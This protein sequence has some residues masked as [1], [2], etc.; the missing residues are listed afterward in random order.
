[1]FSF[2]G[3]SN[4]GGGN[5]SLLHAPSLTGADEIEYL[6]PLDEATFGKVHDVKVSLYSQSIPPFY[7]QDRFG[8]ANQGPAKKDEIDRLYYL[9]SHLNVDQAADSEGKKVMKDWKLFITGT[10]SELK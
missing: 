2:D 8:D 10:T 9:T 7:L 4:N 6:I 1:M 5:G 3:C